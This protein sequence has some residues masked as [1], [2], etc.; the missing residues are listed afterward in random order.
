M[1]DEVLRLKAKIENGLKEKLQ[2][3]LGL[4]DDIESTNVTVVSFG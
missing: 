2:V 1:S 4:E 3:V